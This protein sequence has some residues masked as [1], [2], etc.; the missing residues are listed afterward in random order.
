[1]SEAQPPEST[2]EPPEAPTWTDIFEEPFTILILG[3]RGSG[4][5]ALGHLLTEEFG[6]PESDRDAYIM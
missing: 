3:Q 5:T 2:E 1:V 6:G 4:K